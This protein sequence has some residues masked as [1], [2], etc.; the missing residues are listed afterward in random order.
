MYARAAK[1][2][3]Q[4]DL[5][6]SSKAQILDKL[7]LRFVR[8]C[9]DAKAAMARGDVAAKAAAINHGNQIIMELVAALDHALAPDLCGNL[10]TLYDYVLDR[11]A[12]SNMQNDAR[13]LEQASVV[14]MQLR[15][16]FSEASNANG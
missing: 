13:L 16:A 1:A 10:A 11:L 8:D 3:K 4:V 12:Q 5:E 2:Y 7:Y 14:M 9:D 15:E 6:S